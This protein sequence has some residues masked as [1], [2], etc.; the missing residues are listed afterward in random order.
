M[1]LLSA[2]TGA[3][4]G[5]PELVSDQDALALTATSRPVDFDSSSMLH[6]AKILP[7]E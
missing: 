4:P 5:M 1:N 3:I 7:R 6:W 2:M